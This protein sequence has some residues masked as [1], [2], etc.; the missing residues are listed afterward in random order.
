MKKNTSFIR[1][2]RMH[3]NDCSF[4]LQLTS[5]LYCYLI[6]YLILL[7][8]SN[9]ETALYLAHKILCAFKRTINTHNQILTYY[10]K[11]LK[12]YKAD[13]TTKEHTF[14]LREIF[15]LKL[16]GLEN[17]MKQRDWVVIDHI[18]EKLRKHLVR[19]IAK[20]KLLDRKSLL[21]NGKSLQNRCEMRSKVYSL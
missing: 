11:Y 7:R 5:N 8:I 17:I 3:C 18:S 4:L 6:S 1:I 19:P 20:N 2:L 16:S 12:T 10:V 21:L 13:Q 14:R 15:L 9:E